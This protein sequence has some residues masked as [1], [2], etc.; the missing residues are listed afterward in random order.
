MSLLDGKLIALHGDTGH[1]LWT[2][3]SGQ[4]LLAA[5]GPKQDVTADRNKVSA[6]QSYAEVFLG[7]DGTLYSYEGKPGSLKVGIVISREEDSCAV[8]G[9]KVIEFA[10][11]WSMSRQSCNGTTFTTGRLHL[12]AACGLSK[13]ASICR[14]F[15]ATWRRWQ[16]A[17]PA[18]DKRGN[19]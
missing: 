13:R 18:V 7:W 11:C 8:I 4:P 1:E 16:I 15:T 17:F 19:W 6:V 3:D 14:Y 5:S 12:P 10:I 9:H 2:Y